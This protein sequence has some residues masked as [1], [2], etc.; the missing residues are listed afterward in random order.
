[1]WPHL[2][3]RYFGGWLVSAHKPICKS[4][5]FCVMLASAASRQFLSGGDSKALVLLRAATR[6]E[7]ESQLKS[8]VSGDVPQATACEGNVTGIFLRSEMLINCG[9]KLKRLTG[10]VRLGARVAST[11]HMALRQQLRSAVWIKW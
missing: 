3:H 9:P 11:V 2:N 4:Y 1:M 10:F 7:L 8:V 6:H 5:R